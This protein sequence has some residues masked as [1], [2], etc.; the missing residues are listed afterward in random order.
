MKNHVDKDSG[1]TKYIIPLGIIA[2]VVLFIKGGVWF[3]GSFLS[4][5]NV[6]STIAAG[7]TIILILFSLVP[8]WRSFTGQ[9]IWLA[10]WVQGGAL[11]FNCFGITVTL[12]GTIIG[13]L[14]MLILGIGP[15]FTAPLALLF[16]GEFSSFFS[17]LVGI[18]IIYAQRLLG[19]WF[20]SSSEEENPTTNKYITIAI[21]SILSI[22]SLATFLLVHF[23]S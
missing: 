2:L 16:H 1:M 4:F 9:G 7:V 6:L 17:L 22:L 12:R 10:S 13:I 18:G 20:V 14:S 23:I 19:I 11:W 3:T 8:K 15:F 5:V 21:I